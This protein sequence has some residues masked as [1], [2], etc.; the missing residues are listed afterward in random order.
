MSY[1]KLLYASPSVVRNCGKPFVTACLHKQGVPNYK[2]KKHLLC[3][4]EVYFHDWVQ[5]S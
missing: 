5:L 1:M 4:F 3:L 2:L